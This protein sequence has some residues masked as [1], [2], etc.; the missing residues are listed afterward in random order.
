MG[1]LIVLVTVHLKQEKKT[2]SLVNTST[3]QEMSESFLRS[4]P[5]LLI[6]AETQSS[7]SSAEVSSAMTSAQL[8]GVKGLTNRAQS[9]GWFGSTKT[10]KGRSTRLA[11]KIERGN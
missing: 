5:V 3:L 6:T 10:E 8:A 11:K 9:R 2:I 4:C 7:A 1:Q